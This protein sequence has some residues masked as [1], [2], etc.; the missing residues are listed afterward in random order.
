MDVNRQSGSGHGWDPAAYAEHAAF[1]PA[2]GGPVMALLSPRAGERILDLGCGN[3]TL[4]AEIVATGADVLG[5]DSDAGML[6][7]ARERGLDVR[8]MDG[9]ALSFEAEFDA[10][11]SNAALHWMPD[12]PAV[13]AGAFRA[14]K[15]GGRFACECGGHGNIA[16]LRT[17]LSA[18]MARLGHREPELQTY[19]SAETAR[20]Q[21]EVAGFVVEECEIVPRPTPLPGGVEDWFR[22]FR[23]GFIP[24][25]HAEEIIAEAAALLRPILRDSSGRWTADY[26]RLRF[27]AR[28][29]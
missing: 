4:T 12:Q 17:A 24:A 22:T 7:A 15:P 11:F 1:V 13:Y 27:L 9:Q 28:K 5:V 14:L 2:L 18:A 19:P 6:A 23:H 25:A 3:G 29:P 20:A 8:R 26:V 21:L 16:A 10:V